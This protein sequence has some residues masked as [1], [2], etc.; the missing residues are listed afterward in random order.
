MCMVRICTCT[1]V[2][3]HLQTYMCIHM[4]RMSR[5]RLYYPTWD[6]LY[7]H[8]IYIYT[9]NFNFNMHLEDRGSY[10]AHIANCKFIPAMCRLHLG[11][12]LLVS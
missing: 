1:E 4:Y 11:T 6:T 7:T 10:Y 9:R 5:V 2:N 12:P 3:D 8:G